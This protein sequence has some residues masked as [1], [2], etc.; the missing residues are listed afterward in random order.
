MA[1]RNNLKL[2]FSYLRLNLRKEWKYK[3]SFFMQIITM[4]LN[5]AFFIVQWYIIF[6]LVD[7]IGGYGFNETMLLWSISAGAFGFAHT[8]FNGAW[9]IKDIVYESKLD[10]FLTQPKNTLINVCCSS[11]SIAGI[12]DMLYA[13]IVLAI[14]GA[15]WYW[16]LLIVPTMILVG[17]MYVS[18]YV[19]YISLCFYMKQ[20]DAVAKSFERAMLQA[21]SYPPAIYNTVV[22]ALLFTLI[23]AFF[24]TF[25]P[26]QYFFL[27]PNLWWILG[28]III[29]AIWITIAFL[30][31]N[32]GLKK[33]NSGNLMSGRL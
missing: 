32:I 27:T 4:M 28:T 29:T 16:Y 12:G 21:S 23:P 33:Y 18:V 14:I 11:T 2:I 10:V 8:F 13:F 30:S 5:D 31:F 20:G 9:N 25:I 7:T 3:S 22:K 1:V 15:P 17:L 6:G 24:Y 19:V 26:A